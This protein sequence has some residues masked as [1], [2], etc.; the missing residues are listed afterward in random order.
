LF[1]A[2]GGLTYSLRSV[3]NGLNYKL[4]DFSIDKSMMRKLYATDSNL[5]EKEEEI[6]EKMGIDALFDQEEMKDKS[7]KIML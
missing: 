3:F 7:G 6:D 5:L 1:S 2:F 4:S